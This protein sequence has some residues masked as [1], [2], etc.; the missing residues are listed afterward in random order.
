MGLDMYL[1]KKT[2]VKNWEHMSPE[3][4][5]EISIKKNGVEVSYIKKERI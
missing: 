2:Y 3:E 5:H 4:L 1:Y